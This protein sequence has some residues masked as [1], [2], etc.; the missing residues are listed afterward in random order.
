M[1]KHFF[2]IISAF[3]FHTWFL[4]IYKKSQIYFQIR[5]FQPYPFCDFWHFWWVNQH[6]EYTATVSTTLFSPN[7]E[8]Q[9]AS[10]LMTNLEI[11]SWS[12][13]LISRDRCLPTKSDTFGYFN[14]CHHSLVS[15]D[16]PQLCLLYI[17]Y[18]LL[19]FFFLFGWILCFVFEK[20]H[21]SLLYIVSH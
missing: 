5:N 6:K 12:S 15:S 9:L 17:T 20:L 13:N 10:G 19:V 21:K 3:S 4:K 16:L 7:L 11:A 2:C 14:L 1:C 8:T 18:P